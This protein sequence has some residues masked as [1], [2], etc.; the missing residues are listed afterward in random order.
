MVV[1]LPLSRAVGQRLGEIRCSESG[2]TD[3]RVLAEG[4]KHEQLEQ[5]EV[6]VLTRLKEAM[7]SQIGARARRR[8][9]LDGR[10]W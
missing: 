6:E 10:R 4:R 7:C 8:S 1:P 2:G 9:A 5:E 3:S